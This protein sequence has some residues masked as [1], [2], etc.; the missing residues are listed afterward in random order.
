MLTKQLTATT[1]NVSAI[2]YADDFR[3]CSKNAYLLHSENVGH[4]R[5]T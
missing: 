3:A 2:A 5:A 4:W 1:S